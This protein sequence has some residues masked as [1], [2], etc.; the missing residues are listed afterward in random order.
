MASFV[1]QAVLRGELTREL[2]VAWAPVRDG[3][4]EVDGVPREVMRVFSQRRAQ[5]EAAL[6]ERGTDGAR[7][8]E[9]A[10][11]ATR[12][13]KGAPVGV[14]VLAAVWRQRATEAGFEVDDV[15]R[16]LS[17]A[18]LRA[19][20]ARVLVALK[21]ELAGPRGLTHRRSSFGRRDVLLE[22][23][24]RLP[25]GATV[26]ARELE[27]AADDFLASSRVVPLVRARG[28]DADNGAFRR[29]D[30]RRLPVA[31]EERRY[32]TPE[33]LAI[34]QRLVD[35]VRRARRRGPTAAR[36]VDT[37]IA[38]R[39]SLSEEQ[40]AMVRHLCERDDGVAVVAGKAG[41]GKT[42]A[43]GAARE[44]WEA[45]G[46]PV[47]GAAVALRAAREL[48]D[49]AGIKS[50]TVAAI[51]AGRALPTRV[52]LVVDEAG[53]VGTRH[54]AALVERVSSLRGKV[55]LVGDHRQLPELEA[56]G[57]FRGLVHRGV[58]VELQENRR[59]VE[60]WE[61]GAL[62]DL[63]DGR[64]GEAL[65]AYGRRGRVFAGQDAK[66]RL[67]DDWREHGDVG[68]SVMIARRRA[69]VADLNARARL[70]LREA[71]ALGADEVALPGGR[72]AV[73]DRVVVKRNAR[74]LGASNGD[75]GR[76]TAIDRAC[77]ELDCCGRRVGLDRRF[78]ME[79]TARGDPSL[80]HGYAITGH[81]AQGLT[82]GRAF[83]LADAGASREWLYV[84][85]SRGREGNRLYLAD[86]AR[87]REEF[88]PVDPHRPDAH[89]RL[90]AALAR[91]EAQPMAIDVVSEERL[92]RRFRRQRD[93]GWGIDR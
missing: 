44:A 88:A 68:G 52:V 62:D 92:D 6:V 10:A 57:V 37:A 67:V 69:D 71:G 47:R 58:G 4:A 77:L 46:F 43:L 80:V 41:T 61:R 64:A 54:L 3:I 1:Y 49:G 45:A 70:V 85:L 65:E 39:P 75:R 73:G 40:R 48:E 56:G 8:A 38:A 66:Q 12:R 25:A 59:Q 22:L 28:V 21:H 26:T 2:G 14:E 83:V 24:E 86:D 23:C 55:V 30:G 93:D 20:D 72:F 87:G 60:A 79:P 27:G 51:V 33:L 31:A 36:T 82:T 11:L 9:A 5:I 76:V 15:H 18:S 19:L 90:A 17:R 78:L 91:S 35:R 63:R 16:L 13:G 53:M 81:I 50:T 74:E 34:E 84:A 29:R 89:R 32:S 42:F 7:A